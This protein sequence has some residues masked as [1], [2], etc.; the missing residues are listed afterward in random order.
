MPFVGLSLVSHNAIVSVIIGYCIFIKPCY[1]LRR[2]KIA[3]TVVVL[4][5][6]KKRFLDRFS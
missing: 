3:D 5:L 1:P 4:N 6:L 2:L